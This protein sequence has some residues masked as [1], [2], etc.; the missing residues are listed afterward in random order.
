M[1]SRVLTD[2]VRVA[3]LVLGVCGVGG[4]ALA[5]TGS[6]RSGG[7]GVPYRNEPGRFTLV[8][9][10]DTQNYSEFYPEIYEAQTRWIA[11]NRH[12]QN[13]KFVSHYGDVVNHGD[14]DNEWRNARRAMD[15]LDRAGVAYGVTAG[16]HDVTPSGSAG[17]PYIQQKYLEYFGPQRYAGQSWY[18]GA[19]PSGMSNYQ[20]FAGG[21]R[22]FLIMHL[23]VDTPV[24]ELAWAQGVLNQNRDKPTIITTHRYLQDAED[25]TGGVPV[26]PSGRYPGVWYNFEGIYADGGIQTEELWNSFMR[27]N[28]QVFMVNCG[29]F[30]EEFRQT[31]TNL[32]GLPVHEVL[33]DYQDDPNGGDGWL[34]LMQF[35]TAA[36]RIDVETYSPTRN[37]FRTAD[38]SRFSLSVDFDRYA[39]RNSLS[40]HQGINGYQGAKDT[41][42]DENRRDTS[43]G[44]D[45]TF[46]VDDDTTNSVFNDRRGQGL[47]RFDDIISSTGEANKIPAGATITSATLRLVFEDDV[48]S[49]FSDPGFFVY[50]MTRDWSENSTWNSVSGGLTP[51]ADYGSLVGVLAGD[52]NPDAD[53][54]R[55]LDVRA[56]VQAWVNGQAN[57]GFALIPEIISGNDDGITVWSSE[58]GNILYRPVLDV[59]WTM[60]IPAP[61]L[62]LW[63]GAG[64]LGL[65]RTPRRRM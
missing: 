14:R 43:F 17:S 41:W 29:H 36:K 52:N 57:F 60:N 13:I 24:R 65:S 33:A 18:K 3:S 6:V 9:M 53:A 1:T 59:T 39:T 61:G 42:I 55:V 27:V 64:L 51:G 32:H 44:N 23:E 11:E 10:P 4:M 45:A 56:A 7:Q 38:E 49:P 30:H 47:V 62:T 21:G 50:M 63:L 37:E 20:T 2:R 48:D 19:S 34:R 16:N 22:E 25:Y 5:Q 28:K 46:D 8:G 58:A 26:V 40:F 35:D 31:S 54:W 15:T 12:G